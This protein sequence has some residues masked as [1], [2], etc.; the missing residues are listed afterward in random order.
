MCPAVSIYYLVSVPARPLGRDEDLHVRVRET[1]QNATELTQSREELPSV[2]PALSLGHV[3]P[4]GCRHGVWESQMDGV[5]TWCCQLASANLPIPFRFS[6][7]FFAEPSQIFRLPT[8]GIPR[9]SLSRRGCVKGCQVV[10]RISG[11]GQGLGWCVVEPAKEPAH[12]TVAEKA[13]LGTVTVLSPQDV[14]L[15]SCCRRLWVMVGTTSSHSLL[16]SRHIRVH[17]ISKRELLCLCCGC[18]GLWEM[19][20]FGAKWD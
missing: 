1:S 8:A 17:L 3:W 9:A 20:G 5:W 18:K 12:A 15:S 7:L 4:L 2:Q 19:C 11:K 16:H 13:C 14:V 6:V 10:H